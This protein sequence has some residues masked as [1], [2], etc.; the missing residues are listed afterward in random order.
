MSSRRGVT[1]IELVV[2]IALMAI[3]TGAVAPALTSLDRRNPTAVDAVVELIRRARTSALERGSA[4]TL[5][6][7]PASAR[8]WLDVPDTSDVIVLPQGA[9]LTATSPRVHLR[10]DPT[11]SADADAIFVHEQNAVTAI[12]LDRWTGEVRDER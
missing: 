8:Y 6:I 1:L 4:V 2:V 5:T 11:G 7:D 9:T 10:F 3:V 12:V